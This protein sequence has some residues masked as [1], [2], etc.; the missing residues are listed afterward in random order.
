MKGFSLI[1]VLVALVIMSIALLASLQWQIRA[2][3]LNQSSYLQSLAVSELQ[4]TFES[5]LDDWRLSVQQS[6]PKGKLVLDDCSTS[7]QWFNTWN[8][9]E[10]QIKVITADVSI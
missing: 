8:A 4:S 9:E 7:I 5:V 2:V 6:L 3:Q 10:Q 1:E